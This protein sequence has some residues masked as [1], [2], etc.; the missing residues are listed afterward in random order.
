[1]DAIVWMDGWVNFLIPV[2][3]WVEGRRDRID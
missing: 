3:G 1:M 2:D